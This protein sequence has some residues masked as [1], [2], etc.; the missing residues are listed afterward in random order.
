MDRDEWIRGLFRCLDAKDSDGWLN[1][2]APD[3]CFR[4]GN[5]AVVE[6]RSAIEGAVSAFFASISDLRH[7]LVETWKLPDTVICR[8]DVT[9][10]RLDG[11]TLTVPF[12]NV[13]KLE[14]DL[15]CDYLIYADISELHSPSTR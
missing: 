1:F 9:Y 7:D 8:G 5:M 2:L 10:T 4:F 13:L 12:I 14:A 6:G 11:S 3:V 15:I